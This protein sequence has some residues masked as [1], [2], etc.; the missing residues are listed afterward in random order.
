MSHD[1]VNESYRDRDHIK[2]YA[3]RGFR[4]SVHQRAAYNRL[5]VKYCVPIPDEPFAPESHFAPSTAPVVLEI[6]FGMGGATAEGQG[7]RPEQQATRPHRR[8]LVGR[9]LS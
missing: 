2:S 9:E 8:P 4:M 6:G 5:R 1:G 7:A 3:R